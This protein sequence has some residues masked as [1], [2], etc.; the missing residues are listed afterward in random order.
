MNKEVKRTNLSLTLLSDHGAHKEFFK[1]E[2]GHLGKTT[3]ANIE[4]ASAERIN[5][6]GVKDLLPYLEQGE[7]LFIHGMADV[8][9][10]KTKPYTIVPKYR[11]VLRDKLVARTKRRSNG[12]G[13]FIYGTYS[14]ALIDI[15]D[16]H[17]YGYQFKDI[18]T[19]I[20]DL[21]SYLPILN[22][23]E[24]LAYP[25][26]SNGITLD[27][28]LVNTNKLG[29]WHIYISGE[30]KALQHLETYIE[31]MLWDHGMGKIKISAS[32][33]RLFRCLVDLSVLS[34]ERIDFSNQPKLHEGIRRIELGHYYQEGTVL[35]YDD[36]KDVV[37]DKKLERAVRALKSKEYSD[38]KD[39]ALS[40]F[41]QWVLDNYT[42]DTTEMRHWFDQGYTVIPEDMLVHVKDRNTGCASL[43]PAGQLTFGKH[44]GYV[45]KNP[46]SEIKPDHWNAT[47]RNGRVWT[48]NYQMTVFIGEPPEVYVR[49]Q[50]VDVCNEDTLKGLFFNSNDTLQDICY[51][52][53]RVRGS[54]GTYEFTDRYNGILIGALLMATDKNKLPSTNDDKKDFALK[55]GTLL[56]SNLSESIKD[57]ILCL[58]DPAGGGKS[59]SASYLAME[60]AFKGVKVCFVTNTRDNCAKFANDNKY[61]T[62]ILGNADVAERSL[63]K[64]AAAMAV[65]MLSKTTRGGNMKYTS[66]EVADR[67]VKNK[68]ATQQEADNFKQAILDNNHVKTKGD[69]L[70]GINEVRDYPNCITMTAKKLQKSNILSWLNGYFFIIDESNATEV[71]QAIGTV[72]QTVYNSSI[73]INGDISVNAT[74]IALLEG[75]QS[76]TSLEQVNGEWVYTRVPPDYSGVCYMSAEASFIPALNNLVDTYYQGVKVNV[77]DDPT[78]KVIDNNLTITYVKTTSKKVNARDELVRRSRELYPDLIIIGD[79]KD[80]H[81][82][83]VADLSIEACKGNDSLKEQ[84][85]MAYVSYPSADEISHYM[86]TCKILEEEAISTIVTDKFNQLMRNVGYRAHGKTLNI[87]IPDG[88]KNQIKH[89]VFTE[90]VFDL[91]TKIKQERNLKVAANNLMTKVVETVEFKVSNAMH[92]FVS[93][94]KKLLDKGEYLKVKDTKVAIKKTLS[95]VGLSMTEV[96]SHNGHA[97]DLFLEHFEIYKPQIEGKR[98]KCYRM[99]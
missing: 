18:E 67:L 21:K 47:V 90:N 91:S 6:Q 13:N 9:G 79:G 58:R 32:G 35:E 68:V 28:K 69:K 22:D 86:W 31:R 70:L 78:R 14:T 97:V 42:G 62:H 71:Y 98:V 25:S 96:K 39:L 16:P 80:M 74:T 17:E 65:D 61:F 30:A 87:L 2:E 84:D 85:L 66:T 45:C 53:Q 54:S 41:K 43:I 33:A 94:C 50:D 26:S 23:L 64:S 76:K 24:I 34:P 27:G 75:L 82:N 77:I 63:P 38:A 7:H 57:S 1:D 92:T 93:E 88:L 46:L 95:A 10:C 5:I 55:R 48:H 99:K 56:H 36:I 4:Q 72:T 3:V 40:T 81:G 11:E 44:E 49:E 12:E 51:L 59:F 89:D 83:S 8:V 20:K 52:S 37:E 60:L 73:T 19:L 29:N 15:D